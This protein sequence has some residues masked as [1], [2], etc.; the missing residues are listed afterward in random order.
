M[1]GIICA[2]EKEAEP[3]LE[4]LE[5]VSLIEHA[6]LN[7]RLGE[8]FGSSVAVVCCGVCKVNAAIATQILIDRF[9]NME[10]V[11]FSGTAGGIDSRLRIGDTVV[12]TEAVY[13]D[14]ARGVVRPEVFKSDEKLLAVCRAA[15]DRDPPGQAVYYGRCATGEAFVID[16]GRKRIIERWNPLCVDMETAAAAHVCHMNGV[17]FLAVRSVTD[18]EADSGYGS[19]YLNVMEAS[20]N[21]FEVVVKILTK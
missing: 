5:N 1:T 16:E 17:P 3:F 4:E 13:P 19:F 9:D 14:V 8:F 6:S 12:V 11:I 10:R 20:Y 7:F 15:L 18:T 21:S 2:V